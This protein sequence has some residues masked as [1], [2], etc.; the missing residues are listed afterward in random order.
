[1]EGLSGSDGNGGD[2]RLLLL[3]LLYCVVVRCF[4]HGQHWH[5]WYMTSLLSG[6]GLVDWSR[7]NLVRQARRPGRVGVGSGT[8][9]CLAWAAWARIVQSMGT[10]RFFDMPALLVCC[11]LVE[12]TLESLSVYR[13]I[14][15]HVTKCCKS[16]SLALV[17]V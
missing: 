4:Q 14:Y 16:L 11:I 15:L 12:V 8:G 5:G 2:S 13:S 1:M 17:Q 7:P 10:Y 6:G 9:E 3:M